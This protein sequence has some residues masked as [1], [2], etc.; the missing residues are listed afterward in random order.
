ME[1]IKTENFKR[2][3]IFAENLPAY[4]FIPLT[5][6]LLCAILIP[7]QQLANWMNISDKVIVAMQIPTNSWLKFLVVVLV[8]PFIETFL[9]QA[10]PY[11]FLSLF[12]FM[13]RNAWIIIIISSIAFGLVHDYSAQYIMHT[14]IVGAFFISTYI[15]RSKKNDQFLCTF[16]LHALY[17]LIAITLPSIF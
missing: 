8:S 6:L 17:N 15:L 7:M 5:Y 4:W 16:L 14:A 10:V 1:L 11:H 3:R 2:A 13:K 12:N 9:F